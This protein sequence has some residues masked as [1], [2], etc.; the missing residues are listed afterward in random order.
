MNQVL[1]GAGGPSWAVERESELGSEGASVLGHV[2]QVAWP[3]GL[4]TPQ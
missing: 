4:H 1:E 3:E 2:F